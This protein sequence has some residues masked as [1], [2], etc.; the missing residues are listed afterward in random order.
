MTDE[1]PSKKLDKKYLIYGAL[2]LLILVGG[3]FRF[4]HAD[5]PVVGYHNWKETHYLTEARN[6]NNNGFF[7]H[8]FF[9]PEWDYPGLNTDSVG[10]HA[11]TFPT[12]SILA[13]LSFKIFGETLFAARFIGILCS[14][15]S[16]YLMF[17]IVRKLFKR[18]DIALVAAALTAINPLFVFFSRNVQLINPALLFMLLS[19]YFFLDWRESLSLKTGAF[20]V[21]FLMLSGL[22][23]YP[24]MLIALPMLAT[25]P[26]KKVIAD[27]KPK[28]KNYLLYVLL[29]LPI[30]AWMF[31]SK[32]IEAR[33]GVTSVST[34]LI[35]LNAIFAKIWWAAMKSYVADNY[36]LIG[37]FI[38]I[39]GL[40]C[41]FFF[42]RKKFGNKFMLYY[43]GSAV[44]WI[45]IMSSKLSEHSYHQYP[46][47]PL[48]IILMSLAITAVSTNVAGIITR[49]KVRENAKY[50]ILLV[51]LLLMLVPSVHAADR[52]FDTQFFGL[53]IAGEYI[54]EHSA[55]EARLIFPRGQSFGV[56][57]HADRK[58]YGIQA[59]TRE[60]IIEAEAKGVE[61]LFIYQ[62]GLSIIGNAESWTY[63]SQNYDIQQIAFLEKEGQQPQLVYILLKKGG[64]FTD[65]DINNFAVEHVVR[66]KSYI[67]SKGIVEMSYASSDN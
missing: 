61:W 10:V 22:T 41:L 58:G 27:I 39:F 67:F 3:Y 52:Q 64:P 54:K 5:Y 47:A 40:G 12:I 9:V 43:A 24:F 16:I 44:P 1:I 30:P 55:P 56:L 46:I 7:E 19:W 57:W 51:I 59:P 26:Y 38:A 53:D 48:I 28:L 21:L 8:G 13:A 14:L 65:A 42:G 20:T 37:F 23:K 18:D 66:K 2:V 34:G 49:G 35:E 32:I 6:F 29:M 11:D 17:L 60:Q 4:Y 15:A 50:G 33:A 36:T 45:F 31:Y 62:W 25:L 63:L